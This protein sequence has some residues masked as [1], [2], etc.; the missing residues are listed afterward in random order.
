MRVHA[1]HLRFQVDSLTDDVDTAKMRLA[2]EMK[3]INE[4]E[5]ELVR[6]TLDRFHSRE[7]RARLT[8]CAVCVQLR[9]QVEAEIETLRRSELYAAYLRRL[10]Q[11]Q[12]QPFSFAFAR[13][14]RRALTQLK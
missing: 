5:Y 2:A 10:E 14:D 11:A 4:Y 1:L 9:A 8:L 3:V 13:P 6:A 7:T 12:R